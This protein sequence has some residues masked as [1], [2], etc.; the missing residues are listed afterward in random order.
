MRRKKFR[1]F[2]AK[3]RQVVDDRDV[4][5]SHQTPCVPVELGNPSGPRSSA[6]PELPGTSYGNDMDSNALVLP[7]KKTDHKSKRQ[8]TEKS[9]PKQL[10]KKQRK[11]LQKIL[12]QKGK[13]EKVVYHVYL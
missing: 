11:K 4:R 6:A 5:K 8:I 3:A 13:K 7:S 2:N 12:E 10:S 1:Y 9:H